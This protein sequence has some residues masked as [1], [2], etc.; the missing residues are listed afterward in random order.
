MAEL[1]DELPLYELSVTTY[2]AA[3]PERVWHAMDAQLEA[4][5]C[6]RPWS[7]EVIAQDKR[8][9]GRTSMILR[10]PEGEEERLE[11]IYLAYDEGQR[12]VSTDAVDYRFQPQR[13][14]M[15]GIWEIAAEG[16]GTR[17]TASARHW[18]AETMQSHADMGFAEGWTACAQQLKT[19]CEAG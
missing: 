5:W 3:Q 2:I 4:W 19:L 9:G 1:S 12:I 13:P 18:S 15:I 10:G 11:G 6:P 17:Y 16:A 14:F 7:T 8:P